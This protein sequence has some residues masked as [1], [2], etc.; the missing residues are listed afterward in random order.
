MLTIYIP[1]YNRFKH[2][3][4][5]LNSL[6][7]DLDEN[8]S[9]AAKVVVKVF[10]N[11]SSDETEK[12]LKS[13]KKNNLLVCNRIDNIGARVNVADGINQCDTEFLWILGDDDIPYKGLL[14]KIVHSLENL[15]PDLLYLPA[16]WNLDIFEKPVPSVAKDLLIQNK[17]PVKFLN[18]VG[19]K[20]TF[21]SSFIFSV[22]QYSKFKNDEDVRLSFNTDFPHLAYFSPAIISGKSLFMFSDVVIRATGN[23]NFQYSL[24]HSFGVELPNV[25]RKIF[26][27]NTIYAE[28]VIKNLI[29]AFLPSFL[30]SIRYGS[31]KSFDKD[32]PWNGL[33]SVLGDYLIFWIFVYP[34]KF[35]PKF[36]ALPLVVLGRF[37]R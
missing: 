28:I 1:T 21:I 11:N 30:Y 32:I 23:S 24:L 17:N 20:L 26:L 3:Q 4:L 37:L 5:L 14:T 31:S 35:F 7:E 2:L 8:P 34:L 10:N 12:Y 9:V 22:K 13:L 6:F 19:V 27:C 18:S 15:K 25:V 29:V 16:V 33:R 36:L